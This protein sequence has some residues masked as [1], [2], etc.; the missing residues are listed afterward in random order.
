MK[1]INE[2]IEFNC[3]MFL[4]LCMYLNHCKTKPETVIIS[5]DVKKS[6]NRRLFYSMI[7][8]TPN[9]IYLQIILNNS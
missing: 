1:K 4:L 9:Y 8:Y 2:S 5:K 7:N 6:K 3:E